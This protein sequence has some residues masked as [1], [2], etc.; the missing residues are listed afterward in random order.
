MFARLI[1]AAAFIV[2]GFVVAAPALMMVPFAAPGTCATSNICL[3]FGMLAFS[4]VSPLLIGV[5]LLLAAALDASRRIILA[6]RWAVVATPA[7]GSGFVIW[8]FA[9]AAS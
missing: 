6:L 8:L 2:I 1:T 9:T 4:A 3:W 7:L 5:A